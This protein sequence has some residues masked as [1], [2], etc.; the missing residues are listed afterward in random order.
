MHFSTYSLIHSSPNTSST[1][2][3]LLKTASGP[4]PQCIDI[5]LGSRHR[6]SLA[7]FSQSFKEMIFLARLQMKNFME[8][9]SLCRVVKGFDVPA[10][11][12]DAFANGARLGSY[13]KSALEIMRSIT[14]A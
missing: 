9:Q 1:V 10:N 8:E 6:L 5:P 7:F 13:N 2:Y 11:R 3:F 14:P 4:L 12:L